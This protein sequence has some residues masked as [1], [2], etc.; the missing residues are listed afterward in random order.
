[1]KSIVPGTVRNRLKHS[2]ERGEAK[3]VITVLLRKSRAVY[4]CGGA[5]RD[6]IAEKEFGRTSPV[7]DFDIGVQGLCRNAFD[8]LML[9]AGG[10]PNRY[11]GYRLNWPQQPSWDVWRIEETTGLQIA[12]APITVT[13]VLRSFVLNCNAIAIDLVSGKTYDLGAIDSFKTRQIRLVRNAILHDHSTFAAKAVLCALRLNF[14]IEQKAR[15]F[16]ESHLAIPALV[17]EA[18]K[19]GMGVRV[20][21]CIDDVRNRSD[22]ES[23]DIRATRTLLDCLRPQNPEQTCNQVVAHDQTRSAN[24]EDKRQRTTKGRETYC[25]GTNIPETP[26]FRSV[27]VFRRTKA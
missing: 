19:S 6:L 12:N 21:A 11:G 15:R 25:S 4:V 20:R 17:H 22:F 1:M 9:E 2:L 27:P 5:P 10:I 24:P 18:D 7:R 3:K 23:W 14:E 16:V 26:S 8:K 13:N